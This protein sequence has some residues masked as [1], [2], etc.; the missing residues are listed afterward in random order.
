MGTRRSP[1]QLALVVPKIERKQHRAGRTY[2]ERW[3]NWLD[4][5]KSRQECAVR[6]RPWCVY[7]RRVR[8]RVPSVHVRSVLTSERFK[9]SSSWFVSGLNIQVSATGQK[10]A[11]IAALPALLFGIGILTLDVIRGRADEHQS[12]ILRVVDVWKLMSK[13]VYRYSAARYPGSPGCWESREWR[14]LPRSRYR[15]SGL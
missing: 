4:L 1:G 6:H 5:G 14:I 7:A 2:A 13:G 11:V 9:S 8:G 3:E 10:R 15:F 12:Q